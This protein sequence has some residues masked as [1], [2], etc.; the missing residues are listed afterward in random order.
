MDI[1]RS[2]PTELL[3]QFRA[4]KIRDLRILVDKCEP[5]QTIWDYVRPSEVAPAKGQLKT[6]ALLHHMR[7]FDLGGEEWLKQFAYGFPLV[8]ARSQEGIYPKGASVCPP[9]SLDGIWSDSAE[10]FT[11]RARHSGWLN[12]EA[13]WTEAMERTEKGW[14]DR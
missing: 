9:P 10:R 12:A 2:Q 8:G 6:V 4:E 11:S 3:K 1:L 5:S 14:L 13:L 7:N